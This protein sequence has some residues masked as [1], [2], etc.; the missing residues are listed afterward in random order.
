MCGWFSAEYTSKYTWTQSTHQQGMKTATHTAQQRSAAVSRGPVFFS[1][2][3]DVWPRIT[4]DMYSYM[5]STAGRDH[6]DFFLS[7]IVRYWRHVLFLSYLDN[8]MQPRFN[9]HT[10]IASRD[11]QIFVVWRSTLFLRCGCQQTS[12]H[13]RLTDTLTCRCLCTHTTACCFAPL[14]RFLSA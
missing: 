11:T 4:K 12:D 7:Q 10:H 8:L 9:F 5:R 3:H 13:S 2:C 1:W 6:S 14:S